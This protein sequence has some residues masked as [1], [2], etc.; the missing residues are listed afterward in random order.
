MYGDNINKIPR[1]VRESDF[2][3]DGIAGSEV[4]LFPKIVNDDSTA[5]RSRM[6]DATQPYIDVLSI[7]N[8]TEQGLFS[9]NA[10]LGGSAE[11]ADKQYTDYQV[12][13]S[14]AG[15]LRD[16]IVTNDSLA[17]VFFGAGGVSLSVPLYYQNKIEKLERM[18]AE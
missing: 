6:G 1:S 14:D 15:E 11:L 3:K 10:N 9:D 13:G 12:A 18:I 4:Q 7:G 16:Q 5:A 8:A 2:T 17:P